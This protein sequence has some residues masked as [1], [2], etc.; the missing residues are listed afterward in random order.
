MPRRADIRTICVLG[1]GPI[2]IGQACEFDYSGTQALKALKAQGYRVVL[3]NSNP[4]TI[5]TDPE[6]ADRTYIEPLT[7]AVVARILEAERPD[8][9]LP[10]LGGQTALNLALAL[11]E[12]GD[13]D[14]LGIELLGA[15]VEAIHVAEDREAFKA[16]MLRHGLD[17]ARSGVARSLAQARLIAHQT[18]FPCIL[19]PSFTLGGVGGGVVNDP[20]EFDA[21]VSWALACSPVGEVLLEESLLGWREFEMEVIRDTQD[22]GIIICSIENFDPMGVHT[23]DSITVAPAQTLTDREYQAMRDASLRVIRAVGVATGG[24]NIQFAIDPRGER[25]VVIEMNPRVSRSSAL[26]SK[27]T[28]F[29]IAKVAALL[30]VGFTLDELPNDITKTTSACFEPALDYVVTKIPRFAFEKFP[31]ADRGLTT[32]M[33]S[34]GEVMAI[35]RTFG[36]SF[37]KALRGL[38]A[39]DGTL[40]LPPHLAGLDDDALLARAAAPTDDRLW[41]VIEALRRGL[42]VAAVGRAT[43]IDPWFLAEVEELTAAEASLRAQAQSSGPLPTELLRQVKRLGLS[44]RA[45]AALTGRAEGA[46]RGQRADD[47]ILPVFKR[48]DTCAA[49]FDANTPYMYSTYEQGCESAPDS[50]PRVLILGSGPNRI[51]QGIEFDYCC[52]KAAKAAREVGALAIMLNSNPETVSTDHDTSDRLY[53]EPLDLEAVLEVVR[54]ERPMGVIVQLGGQ[55][56]LR[57]ARALSDAGVRLLGTSADALDLAEDR[58]RFSAFAQGLGLQMPAH[59]TATTRAEALVVAQGLGF[60]LVVRPSNVLGGRGMAILHDVDA[61]AQ[62]LDGFFLKTGQPLDERALPLLLDRFLADAAE[63]DVDAVCD[64]QAVVIGGVMEQV[65][66]AGVHSGDSACVL[67]AQGLSAAVDAALRDITRRV[68]LAMGVVGL[69]NVQFA[70][71]GDRP[72]D[73][74]VLEVNPRASRTVPFVSKATGVC[75]A[76]AAAKVMLG[77]TLA[78]LGLTEDLVPRGFSCKETVLPLSRFGLVSPMLSPEMRSTGE[79][80]AQGATPA[81]AYARAQEAASNLPLREGPVFVDV[82]AHSVGALKALLPALLAAHRVLCVPAEACEALSDALGVALTPLDLTRAEDGAGLAF[83]LLLR[84][85]GDGLTEPGLAV[86]FRALNQARRAYFTSS[87]GVALW[88]EGRDAVTAW[89]PRPLQDL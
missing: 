1:A 80:M 7:P 78:S 69:I 19:R 82:D 16:L 22:R 76:T 55:T 24:S 52:V 14:R 38:E 72:E 21:K 2:I 64:G 71:V 51:G 18:G 62:Y 29:P 49:E 9:L 35:G 68:A 10:T 27:A 59:G 33:K 41:L 40:A 45:I 46:V 88:L 57:L 66:R 34:I 53:F 43:A 44:D 63:V 65:E 83:A 60:P 67:P 86:R 79:V 5:M 12:R 54:V 48:V 84:R 30:A 17:V 13:L 50:A 56:P 3:I 42:G 37:C 31:N 39:H 75:L 85:P 87:Q 73:V 26:A 6:M 11:N 32:Q 74:F 81:Q 61:L 4:A 28:G 70:V 23:G 8:A 77:A 89:A 15:G 36:E 25:M 47:G 20:S 58:A